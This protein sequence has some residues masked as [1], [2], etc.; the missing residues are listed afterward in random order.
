MFEVTVPG[1]WMKM[2]GVPT[3]PQRGASRHGQIVFSIKSFSSP[4][5]AVAT[6]AMCASPVKNGIFD[7][8]DTPPKKSF[9]VP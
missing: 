1:P 6:T 8:Y 5:T 4:T 9:V 2:A 7:L 3:S